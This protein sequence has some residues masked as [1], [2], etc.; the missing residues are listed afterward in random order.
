[1]M[2]PRLLA[3]AVL[4][5]IAITAGCGVFDEDHPHRGAAATTAVTGQASK[6][7]FTG[8]A[9]V[10]AFKLEDNGSAGALL[11]QA[12][13][14]ASGNFSLAIPAGT[15]ALIEVVAGAATKF[16]D[17]SDAAG[18]EVAIPAG[19][20]IL[21]TIIKD[22]TE[23]AQARQAVTPL[24]TIAADM[25]AKKASNGMKVS[26]SIDTA[27]AEC[28]DY[29][30]PNLAAASRPALTTTLPNVVDTRGGGTAYA[31]TGDDK[32]DEYGLV[33]AALVKQARTLNVAAVDLIGAMAADGRD[34]AFDGADATDLAGDQK[35][36]VGSAA[37]APVLDRAAATTGIQ[38]ALTGLAATAGHPLA[39]GAANTKATNTAGGF[40]ATRDTN[41]ATRADLAGKVSTATLSSFGGT[42]TSGSGYAVKVHLLANDGTLGAVICDKHKD[43]SAVT[44]DSAGEWRLGPEDVEDNVARNAANLGG[45]KLHELVNLVVVATDGTR[46]FRTVVPG[47]AKFGRTLCPP[48][49]PMRENQFLVFRE[50]VIDLADASRAIF[51]DVQEK[52]GD[53]TRYGT[54]LASAADAGLLAD[55]ITAEAAAEADMLARA[56]TTGGLG[57][58]AAQATRFHQERAR[59]F[60]QLQHN[61]AHLGMDPD[62]ARRLLD[63][64]MA[65][66]MDQ[67]FGVDPAQMNTLNKAKDEAADTK[68]AAVGA[69][70]AD[71]DV[72]RAFQRDHFIRDALKRIED[73]MRN[74]EGC[75]FR[76]DD[77]PAVAST[78]NN[79]LKLDLDG[80][81]TD[82]YDRLLQSVDQVRERI[83]QAV[84]LTRAQDVFKPGTDAFKLMDQ[85]LV[86]AVEALVAG[87]KPGGFAMAGGPNAAF[88]FHH[89]AQGDGT[90]GSSIPEQ[91][92]FKTDFLLAGVQAATFAGG[93]AASAA[94]EYV[95]L[96]GSDGTAATLDSTDI[97]KNGFRPKGGKEAEFF[98]RVR[99]AVEA[100]LDRVA[101]VD[102][103]LDTIAASATDAERVRVKRCLA[104]L[105]IEFFQHDGDKRKGQFVDRDGD[106]FPAGG[107]DPDDADPRVPGFN[108]FGDSDGDG[109]PDFIEKQQGT[110]PFDRTSVPTQAVD[111]DRDGHPDQV[112]DFLGSDK[113]LA[114]SLPDFQSDLRTPALGAGQ[115]AAGTATDR[116]PDGVPDMFQD[117]DLDGFPSDFELRNGTDPLSA[118][119]VPSNAAG[120]SGGRFQGPAPTGGVAPPPAPMG[121]PFPPQN[122]KS[123]AGT[124]LDADRDGLNDL[125]EQFLTAT[126]VTITGGKVSAYSGGNTTAT[127]SSP[128]SPIPDLFRIDRVTVDASGVVTAVADQK[129]DI[130]QD[131]DGDGKN[132]FDEL[133]HFG[134]DPLVKETPDQFQQGPSTGDVFSIDNDGD[135]APDVVEDLLLGKTAAGVKASGD[136]ALSPRVLKDDGSLGTG[137]IARNGTPD[138][139]DKYGLTPQSTGKGDPNVP[140][141]DED[142]DHDGI[143]TIIEMLLDSD[144]QDAAKVPTALDAAAAGRVDIRTGTAL[145]LAEVLKSLQ[146]FFAQLAPP[147]ATSTGGTSTG[148]TSTGGTVGGFLAGGK[149]T[150]ATTQPVIRGYAGAPF[151]FA[152]GVIDTPR[153]DLFRP[154]AV[155]GAILRQGTP[156]TLEVFYR[157]AKDQAVALGLARTDNLSRPAFDGAWKLLDARKG[158]EFTNLLP[159]TDP[160]APASANPYPLFVDP[161]HPLILNGGIPQGALEGRWGLELAFSAGQF[162]HPKGTWATATTLTPPAPS[163]KLTVTLDNAT[164]GPLAGFLGTTGNVAIGGTA[165]IDATVTLPAAGPTGSNSP[166]PTLK[167]VYKLTA[168]SVTGLPT[169]VAGKTFRY[170]VVYEMRKPP[171]SFNFTASPPFTSTSDLVKGSA[172]EAVAPPLVEVETSPGSGQF[173]AIDPVAQKVAAD[174][175]LRFL[176]FLDVGNAFTGGF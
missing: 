59:R 15:P 44:T 123:P 142:L 149:L 136:P 161:N 29:F 6:G 162:V 78:R 83:K 31:L 129:P 18:A 118:A 42:A 143:A 45:K 63:A 68:L 49:D 159:C 88:R 85:A 113:A 154:G 9:I 40:V 115:A 14:D 97:L 50:H 102:R 69:G 70:I 84:D 86:A 33:M 87:G 141:F 130:D 81:G 176:E 171:A 131:Y 132:N 157:D 134:T 173:A 112:E 76:A 105:L 55:V 4:A 23:A 109:V 30:F 20:R 5:P 93:T 110:D 158:V 95:E 46:T 58:T 117:L 138:L 153:P 155:A 3:L 174:Q 53:T 25:A 139:F 22:A 119:S 98:A 135:K 32:K 27:L 65:Q 164:S 19:T 127:I 150:A 80:D 82:D 8:P 41:V 106:G 74:I 147:P 101:A 146:S 126:G 75:L 122:L 72:Q 148:G 28:S 90:A 166:P 54:A 7:V 124:A 96:L 145:T 156:D 26:E 17:E 73:V 133:F 167:L 170:T 99:L 57:L 60:A 163:G 48:C 151:H 160:L 1:M 13:T 116:K 36:R 79:N 16:V 94:A 47:V 152:L 56:T 52:M 175:A 107:G 66:F 64:S 121:Y 168:A 104:F 108:Q 39:A 38:T 169:A 62:E 34:G 120:V 24:T 137:A 140:D 77:D 165:G 114:T 43:G 12:D 100:A 125:L 92:E 2:S 71:K 172:W 111:T 37:S 11:A 91:T 61:V 35:V 21:T 51:A 103:A 89:L 10:K 67:A 144:P 128:A